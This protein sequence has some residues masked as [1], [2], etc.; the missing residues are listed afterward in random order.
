MHQ[1]VLIMEPLLAQ[2]RIE[3]IKFVVDAPEPT[4][5]LGIGFL[6]IYAALVLAI[7]A[8]VYFLVL[9]MPGRGGND[10]QQLFGELCRAHHLSRRQRH[11][12][13]HMARSSQ[14]AC[15]SHMFVDIGLWKPPTADLSQKADI[16]QQAE[17][18]RLRSILFTFEK[19]SDAIGVNVRA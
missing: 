16:K 15:P 2:R 5:S 12:L 8:G 6:L 19:S 4:S 7:A 3:P 10:G 18:L 17:L 1:F 9:Q 14:A 11:L 13:L